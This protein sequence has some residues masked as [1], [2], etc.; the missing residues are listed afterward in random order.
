[1][2][3]FSL[4]G[5]R[6]EGSL[7]DRQ[8]VTI[9]CHTYISDRMRLGLASLAYADMALLNSHTLRFDW[10]FDICRYELGIRMTKRLSMSHITDMIGMMAYLGRCVVGRVIFEDDHSN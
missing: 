2:I 3:V 4:S 8:A 1:M 9:G 6:L 5:H 10:Q 7:Y